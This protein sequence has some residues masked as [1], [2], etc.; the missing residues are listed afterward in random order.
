MRKFIGCLLILTFVLLPCAGWTWHD[1][2]HIAIAKVVH[3]HKWYNAAGADM[4][5]VKAGNSEGKN[6]F[7]NNPPGTVV[8]PE[9]VLAQATL[10]N[11]PD[12]PKGH[13]YG[14]IIASLRD[15]RTSTEKRKYADYHLAFCA[16]YLGDL[17]MPLHNTLYN[18]YNRRNHTRTDAV[19][20]DEVLENLGRIKIYP[21]R[22]QSEADLARAVAKIAN[23]AMNLGYQLE[24]EGRLLTK[25]EAY[26]QISHSASLFKGVLEWLGKPSASIRSLKGDLACQREKNETS[27]TSRG[28]DMEQI[29][30]QVKWRSGG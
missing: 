27:N 21:I 18:A 13:L 2:T 10:Y 20:N 8:T 19:I 14:A 26:Q 24:Q 5:K 12:D 3:Y 29:A 23:Q 6:H 16:H 4:A 7:V 1:E 9:M 22:I 25:K 17:S 15:Y 11:R 30:F 28:G